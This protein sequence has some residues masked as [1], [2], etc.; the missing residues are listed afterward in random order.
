MRVTGRGRDLPRQRE[1]QV[2]FREPNLGLNPRTLGSCCEPK[3]DAQPLSHTRVP[4]FEKFL[5]E[6]NNL[7]SRYLGAEHSMKWNSN[8]RDMYEV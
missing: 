8:Y 1:K 6:V 3:A 4:I 5:K 2:P 7:P